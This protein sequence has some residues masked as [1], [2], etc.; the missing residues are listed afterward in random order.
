[1]LC[2]RSAANRIYCQLNL[3]LKV[4]VVVSLFSL[5]QLGLSVSLLYLYCI[6]AQL[7]PSL[8][9]SRPPPDSSNLI[10]ISYVKFY[11]TLFL[12]PKCSFVYIILQYAFKFHTMV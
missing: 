8:E 7:N 10:Y 5:N 1:M 6:F 2:D 3:R 11:L 9:R 4:S 12:L